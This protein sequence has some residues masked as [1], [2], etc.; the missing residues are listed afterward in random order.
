MVRPRRRRSSRR[1]TGRA[2]PSVGGEVLGLPEPPYGE[3]QDDAEA[4][5][6]RLEAEGSAEV[7]CRRGLGICGARPRASTCR[8]P[9]SGEAGA[10]RV[11]R[12]PR[13]RGAGACTRRPGPSEMFGSTK[14]G[15]EEDRRGARRPR[16]DRWRR[17]RGAAWARATWT[18]SICSCMS[19]GTGRRSPEA[20]G[21]AAC[22]PTTRI[23][24]RDFRPGGPSCARRSPRQVRRPRH[25]GQ[26]DDLR[27]L[28]VPPASPRKRG[29]HREPIRQA[30]TSCGRRS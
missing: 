11:Q 10:R 21:C 22:G 29:G 2:M 18:R 6:D 30:A 23:S 5:S 9:R 15:R 3:Q 12:L 27:V 20:S 24:S 17:G 14:P 4:A 19:H 26:L 13:W 1:S 16:D 25:F 28:E 8:T 7:L